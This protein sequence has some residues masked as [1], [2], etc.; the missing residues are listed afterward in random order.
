MDTRQ[1]YS[2]KLKVTSYKWEIRL[3]R[4]HVRCTQTG[5]FIPR[6]DNDGLS[7]ID[8]RKIIDEKLQQRGRKIIIN[9]IND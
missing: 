5:R 9:I 3:L 4:L 2:N 1:K 7:G 8:R 6:N